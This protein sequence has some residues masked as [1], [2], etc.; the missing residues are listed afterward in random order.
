MPPKALKPQPGRT[1]EGPA[2]NPEKGLFIAR[3]IRLMNA[4][5]GAFVPGCGSLN[6]DDPEF[7]VSYG[8]YLLYVDHP[9]R[10]GPT[11]LMRNYA[12]Q[13]A[14]V[15]TMILQEMRTPWGFRSI[16]GKI[17]T[18]CPDVGEPLDIAFLTTN[19]NNTLRRVVFPARKSWEDM[20]CVHVSENGK[21]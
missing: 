19:F 12:G 17:L 5:S 9:L 7:D 2:Q 15:P 10:P 6:I 8:D 3:L 11:T 1:A 4:G 13:E 14:Q 18:D 21:I 20:E 16:T